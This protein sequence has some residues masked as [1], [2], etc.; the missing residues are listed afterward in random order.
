MELLRLVSKLIYV[1]FCSIIFLS[2]EKKYSEEEIKKILENQ[3]D[4]FCKVKNINLK[5]VQYC[6]S[7]K[8]Y[9]IGGDYQ[10]NLSYYGIDKSDTIV[11]T[12]AFFTE[13][14]DVNLVEVKN[15]NRWEIK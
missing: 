5:N 1:F 15:I 11:I 8:K 13:D 7:F 12:S 2:C 6:T 9:K 3:I 14:N 10:Y 4:E